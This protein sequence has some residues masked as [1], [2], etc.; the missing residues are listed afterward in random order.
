M[1]HDEEGGGS[2]SSVIAGLVTVTAWAVTGS[3]IMTNTN[4]LNR[5]NII[6]F[7]PMFLN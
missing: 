4:M 3:T 1:L 6:R 5:E 7:M 2:L